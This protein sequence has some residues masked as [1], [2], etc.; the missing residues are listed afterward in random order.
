MG[1]LTEILDYLQHMSEDD[2]LQIFEW[3]KKGLEGLR[4]RLG[5]KNIGYVANGSYELINENELDAIDKLDYLNKLVYPVTQ[6]NAYRLANEKIKT[7]GFSEGYVKALVENT[8]EGEIHSGKMLRALTDYALKLGIEIKTGAEVERFE[9]TGKSVIVQVND[10]FKSETWSFRARTLTLCTNAF[11]KQ[12]MPD[13][14][15]VPGRGQVLI[16]KPIEGLKFKG[17]Y[18]FDKG[19]YYFREIDGRVLF[20][21][22]RNKDFNGEATTDFSLN[23]D[24]QKDLDQKLREMILPGTEFEIENRWTGIMAFGSVKQPIVKAF[25]DRVFGAFRMS[26]MGVALATEVAVQFVKIILEKGK[27]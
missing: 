25:S 5:D 10:P 21:G 15:V 6:C 27:S 3:R 26:G 8:C 2:V 4:K 17:I 1:S 24:I 9:E 7:F 22:G 11:T 20:G 12:L 19:Y 13:V 23:P 14:D 18:H 16:T